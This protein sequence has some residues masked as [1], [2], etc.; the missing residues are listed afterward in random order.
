M[1]LPGRRS[2][3]V[4]AG[5]LGS[6]AA[7]LAATPAAARATGPHHPGHCSNA[8]AGERHEL[9]NDP[10]LHLATDAERA[11]AWALLDAT[12][13]HDL[14]YQN[15]EVARQDGYRVDRLATRSHVPNWTYGGDGRVL[16]PVR[17]EWIIF[18]NHRT[19]PH[20]IGVLYVVK[21][22]V[23]PHVPCSPI[24]RWHYHGNNDGAW[25]M[26]VWFSDNLADA[27]AMDPPT[28]WVIK[29]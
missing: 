22:R 23:A 3:V 17:P 15:L 13:R 7:G 1:R 10:P 5:L 26:H 11:A 2:T 16:D 4:I 18:A 29:P 8:Y 12:K 6:L 21:A 19:N 27:F 25:R 20:L 24:C 28:G 9:C 14:K